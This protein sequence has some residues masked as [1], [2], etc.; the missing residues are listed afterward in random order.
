GSV[1][2]KDG[3]Q[4]V[5]A[6]QAAE[7]TDQLTAEEEELLRRRDALLNSRRAI[8]EKR[9][10]L[11]QERRRVLAS[12]GD[13]SAVDKQVDELVEEEKKLGAVEDELDRDLEDFLQQQ[14]VMLA[15][16]AAAE[17]ESSRLAAR[18]ASMAGREKTVA[19]REK[20][21][22]EREAV[23]AER[24]RKLAVRER[25]TCSV[26]PQ[27]IIQQAAPIKGAKYTKRD[28]EP[29]L[30]RA[31]K[32]M[33]RK[34]ILRSDLPPQAQGL[35]KEATEAMAGGDFGRARLAASQLMA[36]IDATN[37]DRGFIQA[38]INRLNGRIQNIQLSG[39]KR[40]D[41]DQLFRAATA[42][43]GDGQFGTANRQLNKIYALFN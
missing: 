26:A 37:I 21:L 8:R 3:D 12:G 27:T 16:L 31:R 39:R 36:T 11:V 2:C 14:R 35:E 13:T 6:E 25:E 5:S 17:G 7:T 18:E 24:E 20:R 43:Y 23:L 22:A 32:R 4:A 30:K 1:G 42:A 38:K 10:A 15:D 19:A 41:V 33:S 40:N 28:V 34:G 9:Q 29:I